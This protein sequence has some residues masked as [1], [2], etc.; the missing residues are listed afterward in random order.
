MSHLSN[1]VNGS[2]REFSPRRFVMRDYLCH[3][4]LLLPLF[5]VSSFENMHAAGSRPDDARLDG[6]ERRNL[7][8]RLFGIA[9]Y[10][11][12][13]EGLLP[14][15]R[16]VECAP[17]TDADWL[18]LLDGSGESVGNPRMQPLTRK[19]EFRSSRHQDC[20]H[21]ESIASWGPELLA[22]SPTSTADLESGPKS[23]VWPTQQGCPTAPNRRHDRIHC[24]RQTPRGRLQR[25][26]VTANGMTTVET[27][28]H[29]SIEA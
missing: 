19:V 26:P 8:A 16:E 15:S 18:I 5:E 23:G 14:S 25:Y 12:R 29:G 22:E 17:A 27:L 1:F 21:P 24:G 2:Q 13:A 3:N 7:D 9:R 4:P 20:R 6:V 28:K 11:E 10:A